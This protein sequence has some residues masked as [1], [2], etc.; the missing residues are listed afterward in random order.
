MDN[1]SPR[2]TKKQN[3]TMLSGSMI[4]AITQDMKD[5]NFFVCLRNLFQ[6]PIRRHGQ[7]SHCA[8]QKGRQ[9]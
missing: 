9:P 5:E 4:E 8:F 6:M 7:R 1:S 2:R 3:A